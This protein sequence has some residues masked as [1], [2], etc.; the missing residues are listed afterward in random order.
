[1]SQ[2]IWPELRKPSISQSTP[3]KLNINIG[4]RVQVN[5]YYGVIRYVGSTHFKSGT[6][7]GI[8]LDTAGSGKNDGSVEGKRYFH[9]SSKSG[10]FIPVSKV[11]KYHAPHRPSTPHASHSHRIASS[12]PTSPSSQ[13]IPP[14]PR[15]PVTSIDTNSEWLKRRVE[16]LETENKY[17][18]QQLQQSNEYQEVINLRDEL[19]RVKKTHSDRVHHLEQSVVDVKKA[20]MDSIETL[21]SIIQSQ[22]EHIASLQQDLAHEK[23]QYSSLVE[24]RAEIEKAGLE[25]LESY[26]QTLT[27]LNQLKQ[28]SEDTKRIKH[29][30]KLLSNDVHVLE[31]VIQNK[32]EKE[33][34]LSDLLLKERHHIKQLSTELKSFKLKSRYSYRLDTPMEEEELCALC[35]NT[36]HDLI[37]CSILSTPSSFV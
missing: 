33:V 8:E 4:D 37:H 14:L 34:Y 2:K 30:L 11:I 29:E 16:V 24:E 3:L 9:C 31:K 26:E 10:I 21:E 32:T 17:L 5:S 23:T 1:M 22:Y 36:T 25:A 27:Q 18:R 19:T 15:R 13:S 28:Q 20:G 35:G 6:W 12:N 7:A